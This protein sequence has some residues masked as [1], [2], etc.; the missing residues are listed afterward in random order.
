MLD[1]HVHS[2]K[3]A[4]CC[5][6]L[7]CQMIKQMIAYHL[8]LCVSVLADFSVFAS[9]SFIQCY[10]HNVTKTQLKY[11]SCLELFLLDVSV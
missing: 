8:F 3:A 11:L 7:K 5:I 2:V 6:S 1:M 9:F 10:L 4:V